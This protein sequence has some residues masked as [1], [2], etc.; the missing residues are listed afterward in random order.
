M[1]TLYVVWE[2]REKETHETLTVKPL[3]M[4]VVTNQTGSKMIEKSRDKKK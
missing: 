4:H 1:L 3:S 2:R